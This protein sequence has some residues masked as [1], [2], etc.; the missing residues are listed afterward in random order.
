M[1]SRAYAKIDLNSIM[2]NME[3]MHRNLSP[4]TKVAAVV[5]TDGYGHGAVP[6]SREIEP[7]DYLWGFAVAT[8]EEALQLKRGGIKKPILILGYTFPEQYEAIVKNEFRPVVF[9][10]DMAKLL[11][12]EAVR[13]HKKA[14]LHI[15]IDTGMN[16]LGF[17]ESEESVSVIK[18]IAALPGVE[19]EGVMSHFVKADEA[20]KTFTK[21]QIEGFSHMLSLLSEAGVSFS[22]RH[23]SGSAG[24]IDVREGNFDMVRAGITIYGLY[25]SREVKKERVPL[26]PALELK[27]RIVFLKE[28][29][30]GETV[31][32]G[33]T[34]TADRR[35]KVAT[36][37]VGYGDGYPRSLSN[38]GYVLIRGQRAPILGRVCMDQFMVDV[39]D[40]PG[41]CEDDEVT[42]IG[43]DGKE[44]IPVETLGDLSGRYNY[45]F[46]CDLGKR[47]PRVFVKDGAIVASQDCFS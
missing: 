17:A 1:Y 31:G 37:P 26:R 28:I 27:S 30:A 3:Q 6:I 38:K 14:Y 11:S 43:R 29:G 12:E 5:K 42:L 2:Y 35:M 21:R 32:Y 23:L 13:Q 9:R 7:L 15:K 46:V 20:D 47:I 16:R 10:E 40:I 24:I 45:E 8:L 41:V 34:F 44:R 18:R 4:G 22:I 19:T 33:A 25:P 39:S 36:V